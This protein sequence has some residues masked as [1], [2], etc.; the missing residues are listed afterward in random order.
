MSMNPKFQPLHLPGGSTG[1]LLVHGFTSCPFDIRP[2]S[3]HL[4][5]VNCTVQE[6]LLPG[7]GTDYRDMARFGW[8]DWLQAVEEGLRRLKQT[9]SRVWLIGFSMGGSLATLAAA[10]NDVDGLISI[11]AP[12]WPRNQ[13]SKYAFL[14]QHFIKYTQLGEG[15]QYQFPSWRY[16]RVAVSNIVDLMRLIREVKRALPSITIP[17]L[18]VQG[19]N[20]GTVHPRGADYIYLRLGSS[21]KELCFTDGG[22]MLLLESGYKE[23]CCC[24]SDFILTRTGGS[25]DGSFKT[26]Q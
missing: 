11:S 16:Q 2:L 9:C 3:K 5:K 25:V 14:L 23:I 26:S 17:T 15:R 6:V 21:E 18:V 1:C 19:R 22:H 10:R 7:H 4:H 12:I 13:R 24:V 8:R 20:D